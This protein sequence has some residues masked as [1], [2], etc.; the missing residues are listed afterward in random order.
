MPTAGIA[1]VLLAIL[2]NY[3]IPPSALNIFSYT[4][5]TNILTVRFLLGYNQNPLTFL[6]SVV[7]SLVYIILFLPLTLNIAKRKQ[8]AN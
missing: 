7:C 4:K 1:T 2:V 3:L 5:P 8:Y 6:D